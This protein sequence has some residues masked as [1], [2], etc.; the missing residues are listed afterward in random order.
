[1][2]WEYRKSRYRWLGYQYRIF[3]RPERAFSVDVP[4]C[5]QCLANY[6]SRH[7]EELKKKAFSY[8][9]TR[10]GCL[11]GYVRALLNLLWLGLLAGWFL[12]R[13]SGY[14]TLPDFVWLGWLVYWPLCGLIDWLLE[15]VVDTSDAKREY[16]K[17]LQVYKEIDSAIEKRVAA[18]RHEVAATL[19]KELNARYRTIEYVRGLGGRRFEYFVA[20][21]FSSMGYKVEVTNASGDGGVDAKATKEGKTIVIQCKNYK[22]P[23]GSGVVRDFFAAMIDAGVSEGIIVSTST[24]SAHAEDFAARRNIRLIDGEEL[25]KLIEQYGLFPQHT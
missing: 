24:F 20:E 19:Q 25:L 4:L 21:L 14:P 22:N 12:G 9:S 11:L 17:G 18:K 13:L 10:L 1:M 16:D 7:I 5:D 2:P 23:V 8:K 15:R 6:N 3:E